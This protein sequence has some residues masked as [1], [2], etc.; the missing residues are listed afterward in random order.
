MRELSAF[1]EIVRVTT[2]AFEERTI[3]EAVMQKIK[4]VLGLH[5]GA[6]FLRDARNG[7][8][9]LRC[10]RGLSATLLTRIYDSRTAGEWAS[11]V[12]RQ[13]KLDVLENPARDP[14]WGRVMNGI[15]PGTEAGGALFVAPIIAQGEEL[16]VLTGMTPPEV[17]LTPTQQTLL[18]QVCEYLGIAISNARLQKKAQR[19]TTEW[20]TLAELSRE[21]AASLDLDVVLTSI[22]Q[23]ACQ[24]C[25]AETAFLCLLTDTDQLRVVAWA[26]LE[27]TALREM[28]MPATSGTAGQVLSSDQPLIVE[29]FIAGSRFEKPFQPLRSIIAA[30]L[31]AKG[32]PLGI[33]YV[34]NR[35]P[36]SFSDHYADLLTAF[37]AQAAVAVENA[38][39]YQA[40][41]AA[42][43]SDIARLKEVDRLKSEFLALVTHELRTPLTSI[44]GI[45]SGLLQDDVSWN[46]EDICT[47]LEAVNEEADYLT[48]LVSNMLDMARLEAGQP[49]LEREW[50]HLTDISQAV[51]RRLRG[52]TSKHKLRF[53]FPAELP[54]VY[55]DY[56]QLISVLTNLVSNALKYS[57]WGAEVQ[58][59]AQVAVP[60]TS[61]TNGGALAPS[62]MLVVNVMDSGEGISS[63]DLPHIFDRF[64]R[65]GND[66]VRAQP[67][68]GLGLA[69][70]KR[71]VEAHGGQIWATNRSGGGAIFS[72]SL[73]LDGPLDQL[74]QEA[75]LSASG[76]P[77]QEQVV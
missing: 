40:E 37:A 58:V 76:I 71:M 32:R 54:Q 35:T 22:V 3:I 61:D 23:K 25:G 10:C 39:L 57:P 73:A 9:G 41:L 43:E 48:A 67:G 63:A 72:F 52:L 20:K 8:F 17:S 66:G 31:T 34:G 46:T 42:V 12:L 13:G 64:Y 68:T 29:D 15:E 56:E 1:H 65:G 69:I 36:T 5:W 51:Q 49:S 50:L 7:R 16:G 62:P 59:E 77:R 74:S 44:K 28:I 2:G 19:R 14:Y 47:F 75:P 11:Q 55:A 26:G 53:H 45:I 21:V 60:P 30:P 24:L 70:C 18:T 33:L 6:V 4:D 38:R 27:T